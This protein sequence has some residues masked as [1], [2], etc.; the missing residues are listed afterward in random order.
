MGLGK[1]ARGLGKVG[2]MIEGVG[3]VWLAGA[4]LIRAVRGKRLGEA[5]QD[6]VLRDEAPP[7]S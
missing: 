6:A 3:Y 2:Q 1:I 7:T 5:S 4:A